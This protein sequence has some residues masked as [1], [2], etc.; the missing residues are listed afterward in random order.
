[1]KSQVG[2]KESNHGITEE[3]VIDKVEAI[4][5]L[6]CKD[7]RFYDDQCLGCRRQRGR[8]FWGICSIYR[9]CVYGKNLEFCAE[10]SQFICQRFL[11]QITTT[12]GI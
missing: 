1:M 9:C 2:N 5:G 4:C 3:R 10:C 6:N 7:C 12:I 11:D 8:M